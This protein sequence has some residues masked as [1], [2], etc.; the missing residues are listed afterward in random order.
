MFCGP[1]LF[2]TAIFFSN[3]VKFPQLKTLMAA[4]GKKM[5]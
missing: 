3:L 1:I 5:K 2:M 4:V